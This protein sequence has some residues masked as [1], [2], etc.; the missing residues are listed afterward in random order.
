[1]KHVRD[2]V[3][4]DLQWTQPHAFT[5]AYELRS[6][7]DLIGMLT[8]R[9]SFGSLATGASADGRWTFKRVGFFSTRV[10]ARA[11]GSDSDLVVFRNN[12][13]TGGGTVELPDGRHWLATTNFWQTR[14]E[15]TTSAETP[16]LTFHQTSGL[17]HTSSAVNIHEA[18]ADL[19]ELPWLVM[20]GWHLRILM[21]H[22]AAA[23]AVT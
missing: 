3:G 18:A 21:Q 20:L 14:Y 17:L 4:R 8:F 10:T 15:I 13:W 19:P 1:M 11:D 7:D 16:L 12:T 6:G 22:H 5:A 9:S 2:Y 23:A